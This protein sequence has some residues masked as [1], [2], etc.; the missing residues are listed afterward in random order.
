MRTFLSLLVL[1]LMLG[2]FLVLGHGCGDN[3]PAAGTD[4]ATDDCVVA[5]RTGVTECQLNECQ[6]GQYCEDSTFGTCEV[7]C[8]S[9]NNCAGS[10]FCD[11]PSGEAVGVCRACTERNPPAS[12][13]DGGGNGGGGNGGGGDVNSRC[14]AAN[15]ELLDCGVFTNTDFAAANMMC[16]SSDWPSSF[17]LAWAECIEAGSN[18]DAKA[19]CANDDDFDF[20]DGFDDTDWF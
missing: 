16:D 7:G 8:T 19:T 13:D 4:A 11:R 17:K 5:N 12:E 9:D 6:A 18:C 3:A 2:S 1:P 20:D 10:D 15:Q 14:R